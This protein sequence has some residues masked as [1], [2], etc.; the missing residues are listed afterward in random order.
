[1]RFMPSRLTGRFHRSIALLCLLVLG[2]TE[3]QTTPRQWIERLGVDIRQILEDP[4]PTRTPAD[5][6]QAVADQ[7]TALARDAEDPA[8]LTERDAQGRTPLMLAVSGAYPKVAQ[9][10]LAHP[11]V[12]RTINEPDAAGNTAWMLAK[13]APALTLVACQPGTLTIERYPLLPPYQRRMTHLLKNKGAAIFAIPGMLEEAGASADAEAAKRVWLERCPSAAPELREAL[14]SGDLRQTLVKEAI[15][16]LRE[17]NKLAKEAPE[18]ILVRP[19]RD[20]V[21]VRDGEESSI[22]GRSPLLRL[23]QIPCARMDISE[24][25][26]EVRWSGR[27]VLK[28]VA[29]T[30]AGVVEAADIKV[31]SEN[32]PLA[33]ADYFSALILR[34]LATYQCEGDAVFEQEFQFNI[35]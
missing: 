14:A 33:V 28:A 3:A 1:M 19:P 7:I 17:F 4:R 27:I 18:S 30:R 24:L 23:S 5:A 6:E 22:E 15:T 31:L 26:Q 2:S 29:R 35:D 21:F 10:L 13:T 8:P 25:P 11:A 9:A 12:R 20:M 34:A 16:R 32:K